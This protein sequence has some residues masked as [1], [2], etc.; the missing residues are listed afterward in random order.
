[1]LAGDTVALT[2]L[3]DGLAEVSLLQTEVALQKASGRTIDLS[4]GEEEVLEGNIF[5]LH[6]GSDVLSLVQDLRSITAEV[7]LTARDLRQGSELSLEAFL[8]T[9]TLDTELREEEVG[10]TISERQ[11]TGEQVLWLD[12]L[13]AALAS[14]LDRALQGFLRLDGILI[15]VHCLY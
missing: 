1:M 13:I 12:G 8:Q 3:V 14:Q 10:E 5:I 11:E 4:Q 9:G 7:G 2:E 15:Y 6:L